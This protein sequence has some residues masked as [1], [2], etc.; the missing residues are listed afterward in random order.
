M[1]EASALSRF[2]HTDII[3]S[4]QADNIEIEVSKADNLTDQCGVG[5]LQTKVSRQEG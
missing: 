5:I 3:I 2:P 1:H 4:R